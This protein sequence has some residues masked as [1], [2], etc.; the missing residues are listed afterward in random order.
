MPLH[1]AGG[2]ALPITV[3]RAACAGAVYGGLS[4][5]PMEM[6]LSI[7]RVAFDRDADVRNK[8]AKHGMA[9]LLRLSRVGSKMRRMV[10]EFATLYVQSH[11]RFHLWPRYVSYYPRTAALV[12]CMR[13]SRAPCILHIC[14]RVVYTQQQ[15][16]CTTRST[17]WSA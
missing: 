4:A 1:A 2:G 14:L 7:L 9:T 12:L 15:R 6:L 11:A 3:A 5:V 16:H 8:R 17:A 10:N 13:G